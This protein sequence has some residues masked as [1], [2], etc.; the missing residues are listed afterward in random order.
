MSNLEESAAFRKSI[1]AVVD[2]RLK[3]KAKSCFRLYPAV[4]VTAPNSATGVCVVRMLGD[5][6][7]LSLPYSSAAASVL[8]GDRVLIGV[9][10]DNFRNA[11]VWCKGDFSGFGGGGE[12][13]GNYVTLD[14]AQTVTAPKIILADDASDG[15]A[16]NQ[17]SLFS[18]INPVQ[19]V[20]ATWQGRGIFG[21]NDRTFLLGVYNGLC[22]LGAHTWDS[23]KDGTN[24]AW[25][26]VYINPDGGKAVYIGGSGWREGS[27]IIKVDNA[28]GKVYKNTGT[29]ESPIWSEL[30]ENPFNRKWIYLGNRS[31]SESGS[32]KFDMTAPLNG[33]YQFKLI[34][35]SN[36][37]FCYSLIMDVYDTESDGHTPSI[38]YEYNASIL[39]YVSVVNNYSGSSWDSTTVVVTNPESFEDNYSVYYRKLS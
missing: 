31:I 6:T 3:E 20:S 9:V 32:T 14:T 33:T 7:P 35:N 27:G 36:E 28:T 30:S 8:A 12:G 29:T 10:Y 26:D 37:E 24:P 25:D 1:E 18:A 5:A 4:V 13:G 15:R 39:W 23:A 19:E 11:V 21:R 34:R 2:A 17:H 22:G 38:K 16:G